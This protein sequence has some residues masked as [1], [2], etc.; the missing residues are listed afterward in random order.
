[1]LWKENEPTELDLHGIVKGIYTLRLTKG[2][3]LKTAKVIIE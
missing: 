3:A 2:T 1:M